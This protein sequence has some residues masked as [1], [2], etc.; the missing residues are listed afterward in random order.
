M[1]LTTTFFRNQDNSIIRTRKITGL[2]NTAQVIEVG[3][4]K[5]LALVISNLHTSLNY[6]KLYDKA[7]PTLGTDVP[8]LAFSVKLSD[9]TTPTI[10]TIV[11]R[12]GTKRLF[13]TAMSIIAT[14]TEDSEIAQVTPVADKVDVN[15]LTEEE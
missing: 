1:A 10:R 4:H 5:I 3:P 9:G 13:Q 2:I 8:V 15:V 14:V 6:I 7:A 11:F 12:N